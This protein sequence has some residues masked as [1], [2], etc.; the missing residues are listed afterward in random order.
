MWFPHVRWQYVTHC[1]QVN[2]TTSKIWASVIPTCT[3]TVCDALCTGKPYHMKDLIECDSHVYVD[4]MW[5]IVYR[6]I[7]PHQRFEWVWFPRVRW[8]YVAHCVQ[9]NLTTSKIWVSVIPTCTLTV[10]DTLCTGKSYHVE[11]L[12]EWNSY[13]YVDSMWRIVY[14]EILP[15]RRSE[16][17]WFPR[18]HW[19]YATHC[20]QVNLTTSKIWVSVVSTCTLT[21]THYVQVNLT[22]S[23][24]WV[25]VISKCKLTVCDAFCTG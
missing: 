13:V 17:V 9:V 8:Q 2:L 1:V 19:Q 5:R 18:V 11:D 4:S 12:S 23:K 14:R 16:W 15:H 25:S 10:C 22:T 7:L 20:V 24:I 3:L 21:V 6:E